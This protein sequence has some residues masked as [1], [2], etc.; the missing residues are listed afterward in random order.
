MA[1]GYFLENVPNLRGLAL[2]H[3]LR[4]AHR[5]DVA[6]FFQPPDDER[7]KQDKRHLFRESTLVEKQLRTDDD[8]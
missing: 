2:D 8:D 5:M 3:F 1:L 6:K 7:L 4:G